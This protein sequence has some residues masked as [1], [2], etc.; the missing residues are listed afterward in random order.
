[1]GDSPTTK[2]KETGRPSPS[3]DSRLERGRQTPHPK[4]R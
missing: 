4:Q 2:P 1:M 3:P